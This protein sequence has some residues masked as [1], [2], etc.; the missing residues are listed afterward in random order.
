LSPVALDLVG[1]GALLGEAVGSVIESAGREA[2]AR[3]M[4]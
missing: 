1:L 3:L 2:S 4:G